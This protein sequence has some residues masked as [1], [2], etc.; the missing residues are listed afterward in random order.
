MASELAVRRNG[1][2]LGLERGEEFGDNLV[3]LAFSFRNLVE[4][5]FDIGS[6]VVV[7]NLREVLDKIVAYYDAY[8]LRHQLAFFGADAFVLDALGDG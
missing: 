2:D 8:L 4:L 1:A 5:L 3:P 6:E 7:H